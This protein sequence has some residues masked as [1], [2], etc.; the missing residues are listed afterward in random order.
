SAVAGLK[1]AS[2]RTRAADESVVAAEEAY[3]LTRIGFDAGRISQLEL[4]STR[5]ALI[6]ARGTAVD[7]RLSRVAA[8]IDLARL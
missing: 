2:S 7:A 3:R 6:A 8:E 1:A 4:R 5:S